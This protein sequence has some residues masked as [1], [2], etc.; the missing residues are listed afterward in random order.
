MLIPCL[1]EDRAFWS[2]LNL[3]LCNFIGRPPKIH[4]YKRRRK[5]T[6]LSTFFKPRILSQT[7]IMLLQV[8]SHQCTNGS[9]LAIHKESMKG[10]T[11]GLPAYME[12]VALKLQTKEVPTLKFAPSHKNGPPVPQP[13]RSCYASHSISPLEAQ[14]HL[15]ALQHLLHQHTAH[16]LLA[17]RHS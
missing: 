12:A 10:S 14:F 2:I 6:S 15:Q 3:L 9:C 1:C 5:K 4:H 13:E 16:L 11:A 7:S 17:K 8:L